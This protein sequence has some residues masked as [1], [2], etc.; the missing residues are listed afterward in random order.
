MSVYNPDPT[1]W[2]SASEAATQFEKPLEE[3]QAIFQKAI[4]DP[5]V[6]VAY[7]MGPDTPLVVGAYIIKQLTGKQSIV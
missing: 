2:Y 1:R 5:K 7:Y 3:I 6:G 4:A